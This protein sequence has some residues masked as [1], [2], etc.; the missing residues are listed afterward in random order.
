M[1]AISVRRPRKSALVDRR[2]LIG[3]GESFVKRTDGEATH[4]LL[5]AGSI[6]I[7][8]VC[9]GSGALGAG[10]RFRRLGID[11]ARCSAPIRLRCMRSRYM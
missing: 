6:S 10:G 11:R 9:G 5:P 3:A 4:R 7:E 1:D 8:P 2:A